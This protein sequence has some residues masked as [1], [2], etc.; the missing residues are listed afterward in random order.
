MNIT[1]NIIDNLNIE[2]KINIVK[3]DYTSLVDKKI[4]EVSR[5][6]NMPGFRPGKVPIGYVK[7]MHGK[8]VLIEEVSGI[9]SESLNKYI[10]DEKLDVLGQPLP[11]EK[12]SINWDKDEEFEFLYDIGI[13]PEFELNL[14]KR[15]KIDYFK[16]KP[17]DE[18]INEKINNIAL[19]HG[20][21]V[22]V[23]KIGE[24]SMLRG[25]FVQLDEK[26]NTLENG[27]VTEDANM[28]FDVIKDEDIKKNFK[29]KKVN[30]TIVFNIKKAFPSNAEITSLLKIDNKQAENIDSDF[31]FKLTGISNF[32]PAEINQDL[33]DKA[34][35]KGEVKSLDELKGKIITLLENELEHNSN[36]KFHIDIRE[37]L[38][39]KI[40][41]DL[42][43]E[44]LKRFIFSTKTD[45]KLT[46]EKIEEDYNLYQE[47]FKWEI[48]KNRIIKDNDIKASEDEVFNYAKGIIQYQFMQYGMQYVPEEYLEEQAKKMLENKD[49]KFRIFEKVYEDKIVKYIRETIMLNVKEISLDE[50]KKLIEKK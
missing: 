16:I 21:N 26:G 23:D 25:E 48:I 28:L 46:K 31:Q 41:I 45:E 7:K 27:I 49:E 29:N 22:D 20:K 1:K 42:P 17:D 12:T 30:D 38:T 4:K 34:Y 9:L 13:I 8:Q 24:K 10:I 6:T 5:K 35:E 50:Y 11:S 39:K 37:E 47:Q 14:S 36:Y 15:N 44:F 18:M 32:V 40:K 33:F 2:I 19:Q 43:D 3:D